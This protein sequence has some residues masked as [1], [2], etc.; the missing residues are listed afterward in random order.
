ME[1]QMVIHWARRRGSNLVL[2]KVGLSGFR[3]ES[4]WDLK[5]ATL[6]ADLTDYYLGLSDGEV[7]GTEVGCT[8]G[9]PEREG[10]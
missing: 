7:D 6:T 9:D 10:L 8:D 5:K 4:H 1:P 3:W 2:L